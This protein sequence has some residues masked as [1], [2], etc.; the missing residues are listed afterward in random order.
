MPVH[1]TLSPGLNSPVGIIAIPSREHLNFINASDHKQRLNHLNP[2]SSDSDE[3][4]N[5]A[6]TNAAQSD[7][8]PFT[9]AQTAT[10][11]R[12]EPATRIIFVK[13]YPF[14]SF[15]PGATERR[16]PDAQDQLPQWPQ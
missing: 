13:S 4:S 1:G 3:G 8:R 5:P 6:R 16:A 7:T 15:A 10:R 9:S 12:S 2:P 11:R 14:Q